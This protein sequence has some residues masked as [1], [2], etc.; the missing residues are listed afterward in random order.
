MRNTIFGIVLIA[1]GIF[2]CVRREWVAGKLQ[3]FYST[4]PVVRSFGPE[5]LLSRGGFIIVFGLLLV[6][7]GI[8]AIAERWMF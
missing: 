5:Q 1:F 2:I 3:R 4:Y 6:G 8:A 7:I